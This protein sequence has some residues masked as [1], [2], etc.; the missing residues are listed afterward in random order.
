MTIRILAI[1][2]CI[3]CL[4]F[5]FNGCSQNTEIKQA[6]LQY[7]SNVA[8]DE[9]HQLQQDCENHSKEVAKKESAQ[10]S[11]ERKQSR[12]ETLTEKIAN[13]TSDYSRPL[14]FGDRSAVTFYYTDVSFADILEAQTLAQEVDVLSQKLGWIKSCER[15]LPLLSA[16]IT[17]LEALRPIWETNCKDW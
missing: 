3:T 7:V 1:T 6:T 10:D 12:L 8:I 14:D 13:P 4:L 16:H 9:I 5:A 17:N 15:Q 2:I 11:L